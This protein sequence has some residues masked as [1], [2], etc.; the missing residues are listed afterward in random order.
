MIIGLGS[1]IIN[2][3]RITRRLENAG[4]QFKNKCFTEKEID[5]ASRYTADNKR[6]I[7]AHFAKRFV[8]KEAFVKA[9]GTGFGEQIG[10]KDIDIANDTKGKPFITLSKKGAELVQKIAGIG[11]KGVCHLSMSDDYP[12][13]LAVVIIESL[14]PDETN[15]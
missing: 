2:I 14:S 5:A 10:F 1:D 13:A 4:E 6:K 15:N 12:Y 7:S 11:R 3:D 8:A 9:A